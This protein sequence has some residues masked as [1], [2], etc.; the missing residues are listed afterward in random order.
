MDNNH[1]KSRKKFYD[2]RAIVVVQG[3]IDMICKKK[4]KTRGLDKARQQTYVKLRV[5]DQKRK[6]RNRRIGH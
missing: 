3:D 2:S 6:E 5:H 4:E 1:D